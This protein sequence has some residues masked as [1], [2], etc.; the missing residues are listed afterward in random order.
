M[1]SA[2][3]GSPL[4]Q[5]G[6]SGVTSHC[7]VW[8]CVIRSCCQRPGSCH[9]VLVQEQLVGGVCIL[10]CMY[11]VCVWEWGAVSHSK[12]PVLQARHCF[13]CS[14]LS[15]SLGEICTYSQ[16][17]VSHGKALE[18]SDIHRLLWLKVPSRCIFKHA[19]IFCPVRFFPQ[20]VK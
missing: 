11:S 13:F 10:V 2:V 7:S 19:K 18:K 12:V 20:E 9:R 15:E 14:Y 17:S 3:F 8:R 16:Q 1:S 5:Q 6:E 4:G